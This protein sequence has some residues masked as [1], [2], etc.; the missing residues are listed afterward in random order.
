MA[1]VYFIHDLIA[2]FTIFARYKMQQ[3]YRVQK[4]FKQVSLAFSRIETVL[5]TIFV[6]STSTIMPYFLTLIHN[7]L[8][9]SQEYC[10][11]L[12][13]MMVKASTP[14]YKLETKKGT[15]IVFMCLNQRK[16]TINISN[17]AQMFSVLYL[18]FLKHIYNAEKITLQISFFFIVST[19][20]RLKI[21]MGCAVYQHN[22]FLADQ[23]AS[24]LFYVHQH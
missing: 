23:T 20:I 15:I 2:F 11:L 9:Y 24:I 17:I 1:Y 3:L 22:F 4:R 19:Q 6:D 7:F 12:V 8:L 16:Q 14:N 13:A 5:S 18:T 21:Y 10:I